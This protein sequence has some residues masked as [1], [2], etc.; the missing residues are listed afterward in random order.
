MYQGAFAFNL[1]YMLEDR[2]TGK[3]PYVTSATQYE[4]RIER[5]YP[6]AAFCFVC[7]DLVLIC[8]VVQGVR[9]CGQEKQDAAACVWLQRERHELFGA[10]P[11][12]FAI[13]GNRPPAVQ[14]FAVGLRQRGQP[15]AHDR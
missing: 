2:I 4:T 15:Q 5:K 1:T 14:E 11:A 7:F 10:V 6:P 8:C 9:E 12:H 13:A 3:Q